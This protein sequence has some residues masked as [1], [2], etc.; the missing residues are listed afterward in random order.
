M[1]AWSR[2]HRSGFVSNM[3]FGLREKDGELLQ[4]RNCRCNS[5][6][7]SGVKNFGRGLANT[8]VTLTPLHLLVTFRVSL[9]FVA[10]N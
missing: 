9:S 3:K 4:G 5:G 8:L 6:L 2:D 1:N 7:T 10:F